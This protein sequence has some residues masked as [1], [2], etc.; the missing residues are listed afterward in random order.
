MSLDSAGRKKAGTPSIC[1]ALNIE[2]LAGFHFSNYIYTSATFKSSLINHRDNHF[3]FSTHFYAMSFHYIV[4]VKLLNRI[5]F[6]RAF[7]ENCAFQRWIGRNATLVMCFSWA[8]H[9]IALSTPLRWFYHLIS[10]NTMF[11][12]LF[13]QIQN[14]RILSHLMSGHSKSNAIFNIRK[15]HF[16]S[17]RTNYVRKMQQAQ[18]KLRL[19]FWHRH[20]SQ[21]PVANGIPVAFVCTEN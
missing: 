13:V 14:F 16:V 15:E 11:E 17:F 7:P 6:A 20:H 2:A 1:D 3:F 4:D 21:F 10:F 19:S 18:Q 5:S 12:T 8:Y 9:F